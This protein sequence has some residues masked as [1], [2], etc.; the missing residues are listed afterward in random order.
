M[1]T[2]MEFMAY[3][4][5]QKVS[6]LNEGN[7]VE[8]SQRNDQIR[9]FAETH[10]MK[11]GIDFFDRCSALSECEVYKAFGQIGSAFLGYILEN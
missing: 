7:L 4:Y 11:W 1:A 10:L 3:L 5:F 2:Q 9:E 8:I 6:A